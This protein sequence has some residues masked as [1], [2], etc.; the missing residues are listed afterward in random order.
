MNKI[1]P[2]RP[3]K[4]TSGNFHTQSRA[5]HTPRLALRH[6]QIVL[7]HTYPV[8]TRVRAHAQQTPV[9]PSGKRHSPTVILVPAPQVHERRTSRLFW[10]LDA[11]Y[12]DADRDGCRHNYR[13][14][15]QD[16]LVQL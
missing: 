1:P 12:D 7:R 6:L 4:Q 14:F 11:R 3:Y 15:W 9:L 5:R 2:P 8:R 16:Y 10:R 13:I